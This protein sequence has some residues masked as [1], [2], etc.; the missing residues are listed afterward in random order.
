MADVIGMS[1]VSSPDTGK[2]SKLKTG[3]RRK[4]NMPKECVDKLVAKG[5]SPE[6]A[7][8]LC[9]IGKKATQKADTS[10]KDEQ[11]RVEDDVLKS[12]NKRMDKRLRD[13]AGRSAPMLKP[14]F[15]KRGKGSKDR[16]HR[17]YSA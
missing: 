3:G 11:N 17:R 2:G 12:R 1:D 6:K 10:A 16:P 14:K 5:V 7:H 9:Y 8:K 15:K 13:E 4:H